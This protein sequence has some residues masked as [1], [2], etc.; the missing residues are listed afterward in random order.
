VTGYFFNGFLKNSS[1]ELTSTTPTVV[2]VADVESK[3][4]FEGI[5][6]GYHINVAS[7]T[8]LHTELKELALQFYDNDIATGGGLSKLYPGKMDIDL[9]RLSSTSA[10][11]NYWYTT[12]DDNVHS[13]PTL[14]KVSSVNGYIEIKRE[15]PEYGYYMGDMPELWVPD[16]VD[17]PAHWK[18]LR[19]EDDK[20]FAVKPNAIFKYDFIDQ[21]REVL[22][23][24]A[25]PDVQL[26][27]CELGCSGRFELGLKSVK[28]C[29]YAWDNT[30]ERFNVMNCPAIPLTQ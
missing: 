8:E 10:L 7:T 21:T 15:V 19:I 5:H 17:N 20:K 9:V 24:E 26:A 23:T 13:K 30:W 12:N 4:P 2:P 25:S 22:Y 11:V 16:N 1:G 6:Y 14:V 28:F 18:L 3:N 29:R 27:T